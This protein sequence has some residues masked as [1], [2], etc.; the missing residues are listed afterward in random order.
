MYINPRLHTP[1]IALGGL[2][3]GA[4]AGWTGSYFQSRRTTSLLQE[5]IGVLEEENR[6]LKEEVKPKIVELTEELRRRT[7]AMDSVSSLVD[8]ATKKIMEHPSSED[9]EP[10]PLPFEPIEEVAVTPPLELVKNVF[11]DEDD[12]PEEWNQEAEDAARQSFPGRPYIISYAEFVE[13][14]FGFNQQTLTFYEGDE[15]LTDPN[16][17]VI[18][19]PGEV[20]G[21]LVFG[22]G[23]GDPNICYVRNKKLKVEYEVIRDS[24][25]YA[26]VRQGL[27]IEEQYEEGDIKH[28]AILRMRRED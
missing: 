17:V 5:H 3:A 8:E 16:D 1:L 12:K 24:G 13:N 28:S 23:S 7:E 20:V 2:V 15:V 22:K 10:A 19:A 25:H 9:W 26:V 27:D 6:I 4:A 18:Y 14:S 21:P 11:P